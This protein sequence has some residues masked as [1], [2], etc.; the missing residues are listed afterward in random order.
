MFSGD[1]KFFYSKDIKLVNVP[2]C[3][4]VSLKYVLGHVIERPEIMIYLPDVKNINT[5]AMDRT[6]CF[7]I[8]NTV[9]PN[10]F[11]EAV[12]YYEQLKKEKARKDY[13]STITIRRELYE[14]ITA[15]PSQPVRDRNSMQARA[16][17]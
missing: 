5:K 12:E 4:S 7:N 14:L 10:F 15:I 3:T 13:S 1:K 9:D 16:L 17:T 11:S 6:F 8:V 2:R